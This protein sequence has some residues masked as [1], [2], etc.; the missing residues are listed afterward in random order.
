MVHRTSPTQSR[1]K[2]IGRVLADLPSIPRSELADYWIMAF[3]VAPPKGLSRRILEYAAAYHLQEKAFGGLPPGIRRKLLPRSK[4][5]PNSGPSNPTAQAPKRLTPGT[6]L[7]REWR[8]RT[9]TVE[10]LSGGYSCDGRHYKSLSAIARV[11]TGAHWSGP[12]FF[13]L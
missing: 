8:G 12:R 5:A 3:G 13:G 6:R 7:M 2:T 1:Q 4:P 11:I 9:F 10:V